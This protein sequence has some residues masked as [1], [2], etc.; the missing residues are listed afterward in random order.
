MRT[1][2]FVQIALG[3]CCMLLAAPVPAQKEPVALPFAAKLGETFKVRVTT[4]DRRTN[5]GALG[6]DRRL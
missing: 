2:L 5:G 6:S 4:T 1:T 3:F